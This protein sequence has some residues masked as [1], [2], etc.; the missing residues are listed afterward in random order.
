LHAATASAL[1]ADIGGTHARFALHLPGE[2]A[3]PRQTVLRV[4]DHPTPEEAIAAALAE[5]GGPAPSRA[6]LAVAAPVGEGPVRL[7]NAPWVLAAPAIT[8][9]FGFSS[10]R[11]VNDFEALAWSLPHFSASEL[12]PL[13][14]GTVP[15]KGAP[16]VVLGPGTGLGVAGYVPGVGAIATE[17]GHVDLPATSPEEDAVLARLRARFVRVSAERALSGP[18]LVNLQQAVAEIRGTEVPERTPAEVAEAALSGACP[19]AAEALELFWHWLGVVTGNLALSWGARGGVY[20]AGGILPRL[21]DRLDAA[22]F[23]ARF[24]DKGRMRPYLAAIPV[25]VVIHP[26]PAFPGLAALAEAL[27]G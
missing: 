26:Q 23:R 1:L 3:P 5:L 27:P 8:V 12:V 21:A 9:R 25:Q 7:T 24:E 14:A 6:V 10:V 20:L 17:G 2:A 15:T 4:A 16:S 18:G 13:G 19:V 22:A 11:L